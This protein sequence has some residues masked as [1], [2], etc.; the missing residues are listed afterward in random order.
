MAKA[1]AVHLAHSL[2]SINIDEFAKGAKLR[3]SGA[4]DGVTIATGTLVVLFGG[5]GVCHSPT[6]YVL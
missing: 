5:Q 6:F 2:R 3:H 1:L 4:T